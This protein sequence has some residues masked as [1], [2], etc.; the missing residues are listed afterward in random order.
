VIARVVLVSACLL[1]LGTG[2]AGAE[3]ALDATVIVLPPAYPAPPPGFV[4]LPASGPPLILVAPGAR[5]EGPP[6]V[7]S[8]GA[9]PRP[10]WLPG[11]SEVVI[12][13]G[14]GGRVTQIL[15]YTPGRFV[16]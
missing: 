11:R 13:L 14:P 3:E 7:P 8:P 4:P 1:A 6:A 16:R 12:G 9:A 5:V 15:R 2:A 10:V